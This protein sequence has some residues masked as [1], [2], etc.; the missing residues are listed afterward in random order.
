MRAARHAVAYHC[1][2]LLWVP[3]TSRRA[4]PPAW[5]CSRTHR[6]LSPS[7]GLPSPSHV[8]FRVDCG[9]PT[10]RRPALSTT[11]HGWPFVLRA[12]SASRPPSHMKWSFSLRVARRRTSCRR[13]L[14][15][16]SLLAAHHHLTGSVR[17]L[18]SVP[19]AAATEERATARHRRCRHGPRRDCSSTTRKDWLSARRTTLSSS[20]TAATTA[21]CASPSALMAP[22]LMSRRW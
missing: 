1:L 7:R 12:G 10:A 20:P 2:S 8:S 22:S 11:L 17:A 9:A 19:A 18:V 5:V 15:M 14:T 21:W 6:C 16:P 4:L 3:L 13:R